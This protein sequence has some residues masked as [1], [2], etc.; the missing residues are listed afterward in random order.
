[1]FAFVFLL[2]LCVRGEVFDEGKMLKEL[3]LPRGNVSIEK[4]RGQDDGEPN[5]RRSTD[6]WIEIKKNTKFMGNTLLP[7]SRIFYTSNM[8]VTEVM[9]GKSFNIDGVSCINDIV[10]REGHLC[11]CQ[12]AG[13][14]KSNDEI[15]LPAG[16][17]VAFKNGALAWFS[18]PVDTGKTGKAKVIIHGT[19]VSSG[20]P[21]AIEKGKLVP[22]SGEYYAFCGIPE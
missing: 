1:M 5:R 19:D 16:S 21:F 20:K 3:N 6:L 11:Y 9:T 7:N 17:K 2:S 12:T 18:V 15:V 4:I 22:T 13:T 8:G 14:F 10:I